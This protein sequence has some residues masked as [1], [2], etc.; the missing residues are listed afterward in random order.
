MSDE[1]DVLI[2]NASIVDGSG[3]GPL[4]GSLAIGG[5]RIVAL[6]DGVKGDARVVIEAGGLTVTPGFIDVHNHGDASILYY[7]EAESFLRQGVTTF[8]G[9]NCGSSPGPYGEHLD[10][11]YFLYD[12]YTDLSLAMYY[13]YRLIPRDNINERHF[14]IHGWKIDWNTLGEFCR[15]VETK[16]ISP[17]Y[18]PLVGHGEIR[19][20]VMGHDY[21][22][23]ATNREVK[24]MQAQ[25]RIAMEEGCRG[26][27]VGR[28]YEPGYYADVGE[29]KACAKIAAQYGGIYT[30]HSL[31][32]GLRQERRPGEFP[33]PK[34]NGILEAI[35]VG[36]TCKMPV[37][38][39]HLSPLYDTYPG[40]S[41]LMT[42]AS[43]KATL[44]AVD[45]ARKEGVDVNFDLIPHHL[46]GGIYT[47]PWLAGL[48]LPWIRLTGSREGLARALRMRDFREEVKSTI[49]SGK[50]YGLNPNLNAAW[51]Q[52]PNIVECKN[53]RYL[54]KT[55]AQVAEGLKVDP[56]EA[57]ME[58]ISADPDTKA[59]L[60]GDDDSAKLMF[61]HHPEMMIGIDTFALDDKW[62]CKNPPWYMPNE[63]T[64]GGFARYFRRAVRE[65]NTLTLGEAVRKITSLPARKFKI[66]DR[67]LLKE[68]FYADIVVMNKE[69]ITDRGDQ[70]EPRKYPDGIE[71]VIVNGKVVVEK[72]RHTGARP[73]KVLYRE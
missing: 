21:K 71:Y 18:V 39:S 29:L 32:T 7:P 68:G 22:R 19:T 63:N 66:R 62:E 70:L 46:V 57:L 61:Y 47:S 55:L 14:K 38:I 48:L 4:R 8:I 56:L 24:M 45:D 26:L 64:Y 51:A 9:G 33:P 12:I 28:D 52:L 27:S 36:R 25:V 60:K 13:P 23:K 53:D 58:V 37:Q 42:E 31:R 3:A 6:G 10:I 2:R 34:I 65:T 41:E 72:S 54:N 43:V 69:T 16:G 1:Y 40:G 30:S 20:L 49:T 5:E 11:G 59:V 17:N 35:D 44:K 73:G 50:W 67:G 15:K